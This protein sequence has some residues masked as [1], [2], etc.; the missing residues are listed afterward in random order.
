MEWTHA[1]EVH[2]LHRFVHAF[3][4]ARHVPRH[5]SHRHGRLDPARDGVDAAREA[6]EVQ[7]FALL[8]DRIGGVYPR[9]VVVALLERL[10]TTSPSVE[11][12]LG[13]YVGEKREERRDGAHAPSLVVTFL[14]SHLF[15]PFL[16]GD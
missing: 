2:C 11:F 4:D 9:P 13:G 7:R 8:A 5:L 14:H 1:L 15:G 3:Y 12:L 10:H 16:P 6:E